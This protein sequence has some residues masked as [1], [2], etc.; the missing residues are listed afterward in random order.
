MSQQ[1]FKYSSVQMIREFKFANFVSKAWKR[2]S[3]GLF[4]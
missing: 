1:N 2:K 4:N 3:D